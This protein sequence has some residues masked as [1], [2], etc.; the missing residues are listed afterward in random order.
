MSKKSDTHIGNIKLGAINR[1]HNFA[2]ISLF[3]GDQKCWG[4]GYALEAILLLCDFAFEQLHLNKLMAGC[5]G[6]NIGSKKAFEKAG[7]NQEG[8]LKKFYL[9]NDTYVDGFIFCLLKE[10]WLK[11][12]GCFDKCLIGKA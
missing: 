4:Y 10:G 3:I 5:Y 12:K 2:D 6:N 7:F 9:C 11:Q 8:I 1:C